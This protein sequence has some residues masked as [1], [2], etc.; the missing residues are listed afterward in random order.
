MDQ[1]DNLSSLHRSPIGIVA[2]DRKM[3][4]VE[5]EEDIRLHLNSQLGNN[6][7]S[8]EENV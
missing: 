3:F 5:G 8:T 6:N 4:V 2:G 7:N 1:A